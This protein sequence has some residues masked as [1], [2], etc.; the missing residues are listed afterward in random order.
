MKQKHEKDTNGSC[1]DSTCS[2][3]FD[4]GGSWGNAIHWSGTEQ[5]DKYPLESESRFNCHGWKRTKPDVGQTL[6]AEF[7][8][9]WMIFEFVE[10]KPCGDPPDMFFAVVRPTRQF[11]K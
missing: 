1:S 11:P 7:V 10:V 5:F 9:S 4:I 2:A 6:R 3:D 8:K